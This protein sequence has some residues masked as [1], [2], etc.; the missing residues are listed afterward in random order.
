MLKVFVMFNF[1]V[2]YKRLI[3]EIVFYYF[4]CLDFFFYKYILI[5]EFIGEKKFFNLLVDFDCLFRIIIEF[6]SWRDIVII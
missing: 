2:Y 4:C 1:K 5:F 3:F 6:L